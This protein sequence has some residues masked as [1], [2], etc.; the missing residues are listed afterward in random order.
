MV[1]LQQFCK[2][3]LCMRPPMTRKPNFT[4][5]RFQGLPQCLQLLTQS[6]P[7]FFATQHFNGRNTALGSWRIQNTAVRMTLKFNYPSAILVFVFLYVSCLIPDMQ[8]H[9]YL[10][11]EKYAWLQGRINIPR[12]LWHIMSAGPLDPPTFQRHFRH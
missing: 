1:R 8:S 6:Y 11:K 12:G 2:N 10:S 3:F 4:F 5:Y 9:F 7:I